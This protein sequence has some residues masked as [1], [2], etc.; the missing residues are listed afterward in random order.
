MPGDPKYN[1]PGPPQILPRVRR[2]LIY[3]LIK[4]L[5]S[6]QDM[7]TPT[8]IDVASD[9][10]NFL[11]TVFPIP[12]HVIAAH[13]VD[14]YGEQEQ[15]P[16]A[17]PPTYVATI[18]R[19]QT[20]PI[21]N[22]SKYLSSR[23]PDTAGHS[24]NQD[25]ILRALN[26]IF[27]RRPNFLTFADLDPGTNREQEMG[28]VGANKFY[29]R[30]LI[31]YPAVPVRHTRNDR[32]PW[33]FP[34]WDA[35]HSG[36]FGW[37]GFFFSSR[38]SFRGDLMLNLN[39]TTSAFYTA[40]RLMNF[41][42]LFHQNITRAFDWQLLALAELLRGVRVVTTYLNK[43]SVEQGNG[44]RPERITAIVDLPNRNFCTARSLMIPGFNRTTVLAYFQQSK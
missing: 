22:F 35:N 34:S 37:P 30:R 24:A 36:L 29:D 43:S 42:K 14:Y 33:P 13:V 41:I 2:R 38:A 18:D 15:G 27:S 17:T 40:G 12:E 10:H 31:G 25:D 4:N 32:P 16:A 5:R 39:S 3:L 1:P 44:Q 8:D 26:M 28:R 9:Y 6:M 11:V 23:G 20:F 21:Q 7:Q 19:S